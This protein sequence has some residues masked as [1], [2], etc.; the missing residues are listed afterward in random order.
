MARQ[1]GGDA[2]SAEV[3]EAMARP[4]CAVCALTDRAVGHF[5]KALAYEQVNDIPLRA[6]LRASRGFC[7]THAHRWLRDARTVLGTSIIY[8]DV[9]KA[10]VAELSDAQPRGGLRSLLTSKTAP[11]D[12]RCIACDAQDDAA[13]RFVDALL[14]DLDEAL[15]TSSDGLCLPHTRKAIERG[16]KRAE[17]LRERAIAVAREQIEHLRDV[18]RKE[19]YRFRH[20]PRSETDRHA[21]RRAID[22]AAGLDGLT[23]ST[24]PVG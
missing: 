10:S 4:G 3:R 22:W 12:I 8:E 15:V 14:A 2:T 18:I 7:S 5:L 23:G 20:E 13:N 11:L 21:P 19:D 24:T 9:L 6:A 1:G 16:G 17:P